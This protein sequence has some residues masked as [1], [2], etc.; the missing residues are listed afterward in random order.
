MDRHQPR[1]EIGALAGLYRAAGNVN[2]PV[3]VALDQAPA[4]AAEARIDAENTNR[5]ADHAPLITP[6]FPPA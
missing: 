3:A 2:E 1:T 6:G 4:G 5:L